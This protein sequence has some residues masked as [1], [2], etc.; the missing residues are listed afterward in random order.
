MTAET[1]GGPTLGEV[2]WVGS[3]MRPQA[4]ADIPGFTRKQIEAGAAAAGAAAIAR[5]AIQAVKAAP[6][7]TVIVATGRELT[8]EEALGLQVALAA[9]DPV[10]F[11][12]VADVAALRVWHPD[13]APAELRAALAETRAMRELAAE[14]LAAFTTPTAAVV[15]NGM[16]RKWRERAGIGAQS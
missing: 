7:E 13:D 15:G 14:I 9:F 5:Y 12:L 3:G 1:A 10:D 11:A 4:Y 6:G 16:I 8:V 2:Y